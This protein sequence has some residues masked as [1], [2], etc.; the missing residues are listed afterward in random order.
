MTEAMAVYGMVFAKLAIGLLAIILQ[1]NLMGKGNLAPT[2]ALDQLQNYVLGGIIGA[3]IYNDQIGILQFM[4]VLIL[5]TILVMTLKFLKGNLRIFKAILDGHPV[6]VIEK[7]H[8][9]TEECMRYGIQAAE[10]K[11]KLRAAGVQYVTDVKRAVLEQNGQLN[12]VQFGEDNI[13]FDLIDDGQI[14][15]FTLDVIEKDRDWLEQEIQAQGYSVKDIY[16]AEYKD[17]KV[18]VYPYERK[19][20]PQIVS[21]LKSKTAHTKDKLKS[22]L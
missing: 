16:I 21:T 11:L 7:G 6:I 15:Q 8:I 18:V 13:R 17:G 9:L 5:W 10:L 19:Y 14:N 22:K 3:I 20:R 2:S 12:V 1:I 4:L